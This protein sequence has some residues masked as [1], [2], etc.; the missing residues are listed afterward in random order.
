MKSR[1]GTPESPSASGPVCGNGRY[2]WCAL[3]G[4]LLLAAFVRFWGLGHE[5]PHSYYPDEKHFVERSLALGSGVLNPHF[6]SKP[7][8]YFYLLFVE[9]GVFFVVGWLFGAWTTI[10]DFAVFYLQNPGPFFLIGRV[11]T[12]LFGIGCVWGAYQLGQRHFSRGV[13][14]FAALLLALT[15]GH[16]TSSQVV[17]ADTPCT[18]FGIWSMYFV[19]NF[20]SQGRRRDLVL[21]CILAG[22]GTATK[23]YTIIALGPTIAAIAIVNT[24]QAATFDRW[25]ERAKLTVV[26]IAVFSA[27][28]LAC[29]PFNILD[30]NGRRFMFS[31]LDQVAVAI[32][33]ST[34][35]P[36]QAE[37]EK[38]ISPRRS[39]VWGG[40]VSYF[41]VLFSPQ[42]MGPVIASLAVCGLVLLLNSHSRSG[43]LLA[44]YPIAIA[45]ISMFLYPGYAEARHQVP[46]Y[47]FLAIAGALPI[48]KGGQ[49]LKPRWMF[50]AILA[51]L[52]SIPMFSIAMAA[53]EKSKQETR[54]VAKRWIETNIANGSKLVLAEDGPPLLPCEDV[55]R[56]QLEKARKSTSE[57]FSKHY[58]ALLEY[59]LLAARRS[60]SY[61][62]VEVR[63]PWWRRGFQERGV[64]ALDTALDR[65]F[66][67]TFKPVGV[68][69]YD[70]YLNNGFRFVVVHSAF[71]DQFV[72]STKRRN[73][74]PAFAEFYSDLTTRARLVKEFSPSD[75]LTGPV[76]SIFE[77]SDGS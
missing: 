13:G 73:L 34:D 7:A 75:Q 47:P 42:G 46:I 31:R 19:L 55:I 20:A 43:Y 52:M 69:N 44:I 1:S 62:F 28:F 41:R 65:R 14:L 56:V 74:F 3:L 48:V 21:G 67:N 15:L 77:L 26:A 5:L 9:Y 33:G 27:T 68:E 71:Y 8:F 32:F 70:F 38:F 17:K 6:F 25:R 22:I 39:G 66:S 2:T 12:A 36:D 59:Q 64:H 29:S 72:G 37:G 76:V 50:Y 35:N 18:F 57:G 63:F 10:Q 60:I 49:Y 11:S 16:I 30:E 23:Y 4:V 61:N 24:D 53:I 40:I 51:G 45:T 58:P 54:N